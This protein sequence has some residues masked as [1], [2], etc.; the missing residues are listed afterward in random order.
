MAFM[1]RNVVISALV[2]VITVACESRSAKEPSARQFGALR[3]APEAV[4]SPDA[5]SAHTAFRQWVDAYKQAS[6]AAR[7]AMLNDGVVRAQARHSALV[8]LMLS[9]PELALSMGTSMAERQMLPAEVQAHVEQW[10]DGLGMLHVIGAVGDETVSPRLPTEHFVTFDGRDTVLRAGVY[11]RRAGLKTR[12]GLRLHGLELDGVL[13]LLD[14]PVRRL[15]PED[16]VFFDYEPGSPC[17][18][19]R[20]ASTAAEVHHDAEHV[21][22]YCSPIHAEEHAAALLEQEQAA[23]DDGTA[24]SAWTEGQKRVLFMRVDFSDRVGDPIS[25]ASA[26]TLIDTNVNNFFVANSFG[27]TSLVGTVTPTLRMPRTV[28]EYQMNGGNYLQ[29]LS[30]ARV[31]ARDAGFDTSTYNLDIIAHPGIFSGWAGR[32]YVG[33]KGTWLNGNFSQGVTSHELG[34]NYGVYH[35]NFWNAG[36]SI[37]GA[38]TLQEYGNPFDVMGASSS[39]HFNAWFKRLFDWTVGAQVSTVTTSGTYRVHRLETATPD[40]GMQALKVPRNDSQSRDYWVEFRQSITNN[41]SL[42]S[43]ASLNFGF[44]F[45]S[46]QGSHLLDMTPDGNRGNSP[47]VIGRTFSDWPANIHFTPVGKSSAAPEWLDVVVN[48]G[49]YP[50]NRA[51]TL[52]VA[53][54]QTTVAPNATVTFTASAM[55]ADGD[56]LAYAWDF[57][58]GTFSINNLP[59]QMKQLSGNRVY[60]VRCTVSDMKGG[61]ATAAVAVTVGTPTTFVLSG[62]VTL[63]GAPVEGVRINDGTR[64]TFS[65]SDGTWR[66]TNVPAGSYTLNASKFGLTFTRGFAAPLMVSA[67]ATGLDFTAAPRAGSNIQGR[68]TA[69]GVGVANVVVSDGSRTATTNS[70]GDYTLANVPDGRYPVTATLAGWQFGLTGSVRNPI[71]VYG[72]NVTNVNF[73]AQGQFLSGTLPSSIM[74]AP[75]V[76]DGY[77]TVTASRGNASQPWNYFLQGVPNGS[78]NLVATSPGVTLEPANFTNPIAITGMARGNLNFQVANTMTTFQV[79]GT[80]RTGGT[81]LPGVSVSDGTRS[82]TTDSQGRYVLTGVPAGMYT[83]TATRAG[84]T[85]MP[86]TRAVTVS[87]ANVTGQDFSTTVANAAPTLAMG[88]TASMTPTTATTVVLSALGADDGGEA[89]LTYTWTAAGSSWPLTFSA[90]GTNGAKSTTVT[91]TGAGTYTFEVV[92][93]DAGGLSVRGTVQVVVTQVL[94]S[95]VVNPG[96]ANVMTGATQFFSAQGQDQFARSMFPGQATWMVSGGGTMASNGQFTA[97]TTPGGPFVVTATAGGRSATAMVTVTGSG[98]PTITQAAR[99]TPSP[100]TG[101]TTVLSVRAT[102][103]A[104]EPSLQ[105]TWAATQMPG[106]VTFSANASN[107]A[108][109][110]T[111]TFTQAGDYEFVV[112]VLD[113][114]G[115]MVTSLVRVTVQATPTTLELQPRV[116]TVLVGGTQQFTAVLQ[117]QFGDALGTQ[118]TITWAIASGGMVDPS[119]LFT[120]AMSPGGPFSLTATASGISASASITVDA[121]P[122]TSAPQVQLTAPVANTRVTGSLT[123][124]AQAMDNVGVTKVEFFEGTTK[125]GEVAAAPY[126]LTVDAST[127]SDGMKS[128]TAKAFDAAGNS[129]TSDAVVVVVGMSTPIDMSPPVVTVTSPGAGAETGLMARLS[130]DATDDIGVTRVEFELDGAQVGSLTAAPWT[131]DVAV[132]E[133]A[134]SLVAIAHDASGKFTRSAAVAFTAK[135][136]GPVLPEPM[137]EE[138]KTPGRDG[139]QE[140]VLGGCGCNGVGTAPWVLAGLA[141]LLS[142][143]RRRR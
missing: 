52:T 138:P 96:S 109:D 106:M 93:T 141:L 88:P 4:T 91:F 38:G 123:L 28:A 134:H 131:V 81:P 37:I 35:A 20:K 51:P 65:L 44:P 120:A 59:T 30:D 116:A 122:D 99:A 128:L 94:T 43:G 137:T 15:K 22:G 5:V 63:G 111:V 118:P 139:T 41:P 7:G 140:L 73:T 82:A 66:L 71:E 68:V 16:A 115:N 121:M 86:P 125:L 56:T 142:R 117:D 132:T 78:W 126:E 119:G 124:V 14:H 33:S 100:V 127:W 61:T 9:D 143:S 53:A 55:D 102:D 92:V 90:N 133:G 98:A 84:Y 1:S 70:N 97:G 54:S 60:F 105:Y 110:T 83:L 113:T 34:H 58:D 11:G 42:M 57:D 31:A 29:L 72:G 46:S 50:S 32:G 18:T 103:D 26:Q 114:A 76:T 107:A 19:S 21:V 45:M 48:F 79:S 112:T 3:E 10:R 40:G 136:T 13:A 135:T 25:Q 62:A 24:A 36:D 87:T 47:L 2:A 89:A 67:D 69:N 74:T 27:K 104:G 17:P 129:A 101:T 77:R 95:M 8:P 80:A 130:A 6:P 12:E 39:S 64:S 49:P 75:V 23:F 85:F 108:K